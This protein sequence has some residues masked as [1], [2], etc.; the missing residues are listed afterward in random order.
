MYDLSLV[1]WYEQLAEEVADEAVEAVKRLLAIAGDKPLG[2][3]INSPFA[4][5]GRIEELLGS[6]D[7][8]A[9]Y[10]A[11][12]G[13]KGVQELVR[14]RNENL[15]KLNITPDESSELFSNE[16]PTFSPATPTPQV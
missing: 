13:W 14:L 1:S 4:T 10:A 12:F 2:S 15:R 8:L 16:P 3:T 6:D 7:A 9:G 5:W 11:Q